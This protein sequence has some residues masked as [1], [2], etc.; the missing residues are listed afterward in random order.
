MS[1][2]NFKS[3]EYFLPAPIRRERRYVIAY[4]HDGTDGEWVMAHKFTGPDARIHAR[5]TFDQIK[6]DFQNSD[7]A[8]FFYWEG[9]DWREGA[10]RY[11]AY[12]WPNKS[13]PTGTFSFIN[14]LDAGYF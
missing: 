11:A 7:L 14:E 12:N 3:D 10:I 13:I 5:R 6:S 4:R 9:D 2:Q 8:I 1:N